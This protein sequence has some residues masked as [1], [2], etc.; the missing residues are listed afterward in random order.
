MAWIMG[1]TLSKAAHAVLDVLIRD[2]ASILTHEEHIAEQS[3]LWATAIRCAQVSLT[4]LP[5]DDLADD[6]LAIAGRQHES[7]FLTG[8]AAGRAM[9]AVSRRIRGMWEDSKTHFEQVVVSN[10]IPQ[11]RKSPRGIR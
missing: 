8:A 2:T 6:V 1:D 5:L 10:G 7:W 3:P 11:D 4:Q 9:G